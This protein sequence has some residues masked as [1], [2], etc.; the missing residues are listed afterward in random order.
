MPF[1]V[2][3]GNADVQW[4]RDGAV[5]MLTLALGQ[6]RDLR[7]ADYERT[8]VLVRDAGL[9]APRG[10]RPRARDRA[11]GGRRHRGDGSRS[12]PLRTRCWWTRGSTT[13]PAARRSTGARAPR[14]SDADP[15]PLFDDLARYLL[16]VAGGH[17]SASVEIARATTTSIE[18]YRAYLDGVRLLQGW[19][20]QAGR[21][22]VP[23]GHSRGLDLRARVAQA[24]ARTR[25]GRRGRRGVLRERRARGG[26]LGPA[27]AASRPSC[28]DISPSYAAQRLGHFGHG[29][30]RA[31]ADA[32][33]I[34]RELL[35]TDPLAAEAWYGLGDAYFHDSVPS[36]TRSRRSPRASASRRARST[37]RCSSTPPSTSRTRTWCSSTSSSRSPGASW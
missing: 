37:G 35:A 25:L 7:V 27:A 33:R 17:A 22:G 26:A 5:N 30:P 18:A 1:D 4:L 9:E 16:D 12:P 8:L 28:A 29:G 2:Q 3:S 10:P 21:L 23:G 14:H 32:Q 31:L 24:R 20:L 11:Q 19:R 6:W 13:S 36:P 34:Y 15:R